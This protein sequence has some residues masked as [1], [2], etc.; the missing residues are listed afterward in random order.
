MEPTFNTLIAPFAEPAPP[1]TP[2]DS[3]LALVTCSYRGRHGAQA[4][5][6]DR[7]YTLQYQP[8]SCLAPVL[9]RSKAPRLWAA[10]AR[11]GGTWSAPGSW[12]R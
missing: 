2:I 4:S 1:P 3:H 11:A 8:A 6:E 7:R 12:Q 9:W 5:E 10:R